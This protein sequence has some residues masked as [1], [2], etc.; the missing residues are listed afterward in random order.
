MPP[1]PFKGEGLVQDNAIAHDVNED[2]LSDLVLNQTSFR[3]ADPGAPQVI[4]IPSRGRVSG[5]GPGLERLRAG[6]SDRNH[7]QL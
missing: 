1:P 2:D 4:Q 6:V 5:G 7:F 3:S